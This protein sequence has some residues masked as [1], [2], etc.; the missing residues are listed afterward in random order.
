MIAAL[1]IPC[2]VMGQE[3]NTDYQMVQLSAMKCK[4]GKYE[5]FEAAVKKHNVKFHKDKYASN[6]WTINT[7][8]QSGTYVWSM[9]LLT[10]TDMDGAPG[11]G[12]HAKDWKENVEIYVSEYGVVEYWTLAKEMS[13]SDDKIQKYQTVWILDIKK[14]NFHRFEEFMKKAV[15]INKKMG[16]EINTWTNRFNEDNG[17]DV[18]IVFTYDKYAELDLMDWK[19]E[20][21]FEK[22][23][24]KGSWVK[25][26]KDWNEFTN[27]N[28]R[29]QW[30]IVE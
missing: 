4:I 21:E 20:E 18:A 9:G 28:Q 19:M 24:G 14:D 17:R 3:S 2:I 30:S 13:Y 8:S 6:L 1:I 7:G 27:R 22:E 5:E 16:T 10:F 11:K 29:S 26:L 25:A 12:D 23:Y 15:A